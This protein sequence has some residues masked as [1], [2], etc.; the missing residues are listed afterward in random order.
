ML[1]EADPRRRTPPPT[2][3]PTTLYPL[4]L[5]SLA[6]CGRYAPSS[7]KNKW[8]AVCAQFPHAV[9]TK[10]KGWQPSF[11]CFTDLFPDSCSPLTVWKKSAEEALN[12]QRQ[13]K[14]WKLTVHELM[15]NTHPD[16]QTFLCFPDY[17]SAI[18]AFCS[19]FFSPC[20][21]LCGCQWASTVEI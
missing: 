12:L 8:V 2:P 17:W 18:L 20:P 4:S 19:Y 6:G 13:D 1:V 5:G 3:P 15:C 14:N 10:K 16:T 7:I 21:S 9:N 11:P